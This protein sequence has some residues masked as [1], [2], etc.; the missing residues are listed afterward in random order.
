[1]LTIFSITRKT[2]PVITKLSNTKKELALARAN[3]HLTCFTFLTFLIL[4]YLT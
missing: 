1:M 3:P 4:S 2:I